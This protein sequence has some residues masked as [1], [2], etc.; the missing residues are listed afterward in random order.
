MSY[1][2]LSDAIFRPSLSKV[3]TDETSF[4]F[5]MQAG[6]CTLQRMLGALMEMAC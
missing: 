3:I 6:L 5:A 2:S 4:A 1:F